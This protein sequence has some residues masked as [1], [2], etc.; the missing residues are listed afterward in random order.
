MTLTP[1]MAKRQ[2]T[3][4][5]VAH[6]KTLRNDPHS[7][8]A[9]TDLRK[10]LT[11]R[12]N[13]VVARAAEMVGEF[14]IKSLAPELSAAFQRLTI[15]SSKTDPQCLAKTAIVEALVRIE[16]DDHD[17]FRQGMQYRQPEPV[18]G[19][20][21]DS[22][23]R[24]AQRVRGGFEQAVVDEPADGTFEAAPFLWSRPNAGRE[25]QAHEKLL[26]HQVGRLGQ[27]TS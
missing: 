18:W 7:P 19:G 10:S 12:S 25:A 26:F 22:A 16:Q 20:E 21:Q 8:A 13:Y 6:L 3:E 5:K 11:D 24:E 1:T 23:A 4:T 15:D 2:T 27:G 17:F 14:E 9:L